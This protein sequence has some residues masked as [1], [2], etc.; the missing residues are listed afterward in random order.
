MPFQENFPYIVV[1]PM[2]KTLSDTNMHLLVQQM[3]GE[4]E[5]V[6]TAP[7][8]APTAAHTGS[9]KKYL[10]VLNRAT[11]FAFRRRTCTASNL[12]DKPNQVDEF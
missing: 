4:Q 9:W 8:L 1:Q 7:Q 3:V 2:E 12:F 6:L 11:I 5:Q 10:A